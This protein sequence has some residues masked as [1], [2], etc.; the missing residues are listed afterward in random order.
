MKYAAMNIHF[1]FLSFLGTSSWIDF[2][3]PEIRKWWAGKFALNEYQVLI[4]L[5]VLW[6]KCLEV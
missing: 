4:V 5:N 2:L 3:N 1:Y 6:F